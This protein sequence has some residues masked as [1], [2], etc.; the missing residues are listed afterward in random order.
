VP[1]LLIL[2]ATAAL[3]GACTHLPD[4]GERIISSAQTPDYTCLKTGT[5]IRL[6]EE[7]CAT[8]SGRV[9]TQT[10]IERSGAFTLSEAL[11]RLDPSL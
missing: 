11:Q 4:S 1:K 8:S 3:L 5:R 9:Y 7:D 6:N 2:I 10:D